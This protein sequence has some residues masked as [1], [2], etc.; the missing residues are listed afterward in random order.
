MK[1]TGLTL[2]EE[3]KIDIE[4]AKI[5]FHTKR[6]SIPHLHLHVIVKPY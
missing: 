2:L 3:H 4:E 1:Q 6:F 5:G